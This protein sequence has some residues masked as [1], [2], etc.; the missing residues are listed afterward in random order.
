MKWMLWI[1]RPKDEGW[2]LL[3]ESKNGGELMAMAEQL[4]RLNCATP[5]T[6]RL[7]GTYEESDFS[8]L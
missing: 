8:Q 2:T 3:A 5:I 4:M 6:V 1:T 7:V